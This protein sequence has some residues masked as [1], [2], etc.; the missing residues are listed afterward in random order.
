M[1]STNAEAARAHALGTP[2]PFWLIAH[3]QS[4]GRGRA[5]RNWVDAGT[6]NFFGT[7]LM[8]V[9]E[10]AAAAAQRSF[11]AAL[12][13]AD[14]LEGAGVAQIRLKWPNDVLLR[15]GKLAG[16]LLESEIVAGRLMLRVGI[17][18][19]LAATPD[20]TD[21]EKEARRPVHLDGVLTPEAFL[22]RLAPAFA[23]RDKQLKTHGFA[24]IRT[25]WLSKAARLG[26]E[27]R[28]RLPGVEHRGT[29]ETVDETGALVLKTPEGRIKLPAGDVFF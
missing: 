4:A 19:N 23:T 16:I 25:A 15:G 26:E 11:V 29:F 17:G 14:V 24:P 1:D 8:E 20:R 27:I 21:L 10:G 12:A 28:A 13:V 22:D 2:A 9:P 6:G 18:V 7:L 5:G 3:H